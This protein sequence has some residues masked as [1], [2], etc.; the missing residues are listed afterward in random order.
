MSI[1]NKTQH[2]SMRHV[3]IL[4]AALSLLVLSSCGTDKEESNDSSNSSIVFEKADPVSVQNQENSA[5]EGKNSNPYDESTG[6][7]TFHINGEPAVVHTISE[8][9]KTT[10]NDYLQ[11][12]SDYL[13]TAA[14]SAYESFIPEEVKR[15]KTLVGGSG[16]IRFALGLVD[17]DDI[18]ELFIGYETRTPCGILIYTYDPANDRVIPLGEFSQFG[19]CYYTEKR[20][21]IWSQYGNQG[22]YRLYFSEIKDGS[23]RLIGTL[24]DNDT[25]YYANFPAPEGETGEKSTI[26]HYGNPGDE[27]RVSEDEFWKVY[28][29]YQR[30]DGKDGT[31]ILKMSYEDM[32]IIDP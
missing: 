18:P 28:D 1:R 15:L 21:S 32:T 14:I 2:T 12:E 17:E 13:D 5:V 8:Y 25:E 24:L 30:S 22:F 23:I 16:G 27:Y 19:F 11:N 3:A 31:R 20:N 4:M 6:D 26:T 10:D 9:L 29:E 7:L